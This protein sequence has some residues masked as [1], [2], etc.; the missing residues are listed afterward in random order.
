MSLEI[1]DVDY[2]RY[3]TVLG[4]A[5]FT[6]RSL[7]E[8][9]E[10]VQELKPTDLAI[11]L[12]MDRFRI[13]QGLNG[14]SMVQALKCE[15]I[16]AVEAFGNSNADIWLIDMS[17]NEMRMRMGAAPENRH[18]WYS[19]IG[20]PWFRPVD[21]EYRMWELG[22][23]DEVLKRNVERL[24]NLR[25]RAPHIWRVLIEE[26]NTIM[27][28]RIAWIATQRIDRGEEPKILAVVGAAHVEGIESLL[29]RPEEI[30]ENLR[31]YGLKFSPPKLIRKININ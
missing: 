22:L 21:D 7:R 26:R 5:H 2:T 12:D 27:A 25:R 3:V 17:E 19:R 30:G 1:L 29:R 31:R 6:L 8:A 23:K 14:S 4:T 18:E 10:A 16:G 20:Y 13:L 9:C 11:E 24:E 15:F 28:A